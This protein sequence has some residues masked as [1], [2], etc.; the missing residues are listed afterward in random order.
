[1]KNLFV[2]ILLTLLQSLT[3]TLSM[4]QSTLLNNLWTDENFSTTIEFDSLNIIRIDD[5]PFV[6]NMSNDTLFLIQ[7]GYADNIIIKIVKLTKDS[8]WLYP[9]SPNAWEYI[10]KDTH[11][12][13]DYGLRF[14]INS[15]FRKI[16]YYSFSE[17]GGEKS[18][19]INKKGE[20]ILKGKLDISEKE[21]EIYNRKL[22]SEQMR[23]LN[24]LCRGL[25]TDFSKRPSKPKHKP[26]VRTTNLHIHH[27]FIKFKNGKKITD[28]DFYST[29]FLIR[30]LLEL[31]EN[32]AMVIESK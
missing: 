22:N 29:K 4:A 32:A 24:N 18:I 25:T 1:M 20:I 6:Y 3:T 19:K 12:F 8:L 7:Y 14:K 13:F 2:C 11:K 28:R 15:D 16:Y 27:Y 21:E 30:Y 17:Y 31:Y 23:K 5:A 26:K 10:G 9:V